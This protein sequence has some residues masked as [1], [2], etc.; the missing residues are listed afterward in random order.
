[1]TAWIGLTG[2]IG[3]GKSAATDLFMQQGVSVIDADA[4]SRSLTAHQGKALPAI[5]AVFGNKSVF[6]GRLN[7]DYMRDLIFKRPEAKAELEAILHPLILQS[8]QQQQEAMTAA[9]CYCG[10]SF[11]DRVAAVSYFGASDIGD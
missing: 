3:S 10:H 9:L 2:G 1:M 4:I 6:D 11:V 8:I 7:R 5:Q